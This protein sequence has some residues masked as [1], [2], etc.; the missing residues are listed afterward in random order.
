MLRVKGWA[1]DGLSD[2]Q[3]CQNM[4]IGQ[5]TFYEWIE[6]FP[7]FAQAIKEGKEPVDIQVENALLKSAIGYTVTLRKPIK[8][9]T[10]KQLKDKGTIEE[11]H[12]E[13]AEEEIHI[14]AQ[15]A[16]QIFWLKNRK[17]TQWRDKRETEVKTD[18]PV[19]VI[20]DV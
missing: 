3:I 6:R 14:P 12:I 2:I 5:R 7:Q 13:Y 17:P 20:L 9:H 15:T 10:K 16:A 19:K 4:G 18:E 1:R 8:V 11:E